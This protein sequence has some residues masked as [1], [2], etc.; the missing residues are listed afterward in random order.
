MAA[1]KWL[2]LRA[3]SAVL[4]VPFARL[5]HRLLHGPTLGGG[6]RVERR[7]QRAIEFVH[8][9]IQ[10]GRLKTAG[11]AVFY[12]LPHGV[13]VRVQGAC[14]AGAKQIA[15]TV[16]AR[17][18]V[19]A[20]AMNRARVE[21]HAAA[22]VGQERASNLSLVVLFAVHIGGSLRVLCCPIANPSDL[23]TGLGSQQG[24]GK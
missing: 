7:D 18:Q 6:W 9:T 11:E 5:E 21:D 4:S 8:R 24:I 19:P 14:I 23:A 16:L 13:R 15:I 10:S 2:L 1:T 20:A 3:A 17:K 22:F 12:A